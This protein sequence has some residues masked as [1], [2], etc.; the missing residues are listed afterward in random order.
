MKTRDP[1][2]THMP[3]RPPNE[4][5]WKP[6]VLC[7]AQLT[8]LGALVDTQRAKGSWRPMKGG[9]R[10]IPL[11]TKKFVCCAILRV[12]SKVGAAN[13]S[14]ARRRGCQRGTFHAKKELSF[15][16]RS[17]LMDA[18]QY[19]DTVVVPNYWDASQHP[20]NFRLVSNSITCMNTVAEFVALE[21]L[22]THLS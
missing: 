11:R 20:N 14:N 13:C 1:R 15:V 6:C 8:T 2:A 16:P 3:P 21:R 7:L 18:K 17:G 10:P 19:F 9:V 22:G 5:V 12:A 4:H